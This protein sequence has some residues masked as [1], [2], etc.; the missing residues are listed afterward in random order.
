LDDFDSLTYADATM[1]F[2]GLLLVAFGCLWLSGAVFNW[3]WFWERGKQ[4]F[5]AQ[6]FGREAARVLYG[7]LGAGA[8]VFGI[9]ATIGVFEQVNR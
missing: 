5:G 2:W 7:I 6:L 3:D 1:N 4:G 8:I 9:L